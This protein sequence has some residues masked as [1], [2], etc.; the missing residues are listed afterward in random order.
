[1][2]I[3]PKCG[4]AVR[5]GKAFCFNCGAQMNA[6]RD[7]TQEEEETPPEFRETVIDAPPR[8]RA[9]QTP[10]PPPYASPDKVAPKDSAQAGA[11]KPELTD[12]LTRRAFLSRRTWIIIVLLL[13]LL[14]L[15]FIVFAVLVD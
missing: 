7:A 1:M 10:T 13:L 8:A 12:A 2:S 5:E 11:A 6:A 9:A 4:A 3:C 14:I 15:G